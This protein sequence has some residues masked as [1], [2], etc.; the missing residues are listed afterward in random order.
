[1]FHLCFQENLFYKFFNL[2]IIY[3]LKNNDDNL[4]L[5]YQALNLFVIFITIL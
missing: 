5:E 4:N 1:M 2:L 3:K